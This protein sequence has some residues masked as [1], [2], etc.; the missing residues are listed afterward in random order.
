VDRPRRL[1][2]GVGSIQLRVSDDDLF[3]V[4]LDLDVHTFQRKHKQKR[5]GRNRRPWVAMA[6]SNQEPASYSESAGN[7]LAIRLQ[8]FVTGRQKRRPRRE[9]GTDRM[10]SLTLLAAGA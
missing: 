9:R 10:R 2:R 8:R 5:A 4:E 3:A 1:D 7:I 6:N